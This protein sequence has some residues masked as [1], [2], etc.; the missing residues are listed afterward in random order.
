MNP[1]I[2]EKGIGILLVGWLAISGSFY[3]MQEIDN[4]PIADTGEVF[5][6]DYLAS[7][8][9]E[10]YEELLSQIDDP[11]KVYLFDIDADI[12]N[13]F[14]EW[15]H[16][17]ELDPQASPVLEAGRNKLPKAKF[18]VKPSTLKKIFNPE[19]KTEFLYPQPPKPDKK[20]PPPE[21]TFWQKVFR[22]LFGNPKAW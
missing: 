15:A 2:I 9:K 6:E 13:E 10:A 5:Y 8:H 7:R 4:V 18:L 16:N 21:L 14:V 12:W 22:E 1:V 17:N 20:N 11:T 3:A 19:G